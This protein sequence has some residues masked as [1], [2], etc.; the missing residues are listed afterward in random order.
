MAESTPTTR[1]ADPEQ[2]AGPQ[3]QPELRE[4][5]QSDPTPTTL[6]RRDYGA[7]LVRGVREA[8][9]DHVT[10]LQ[11]RSPTTGSSRCR[12]RCSSASAS[13]A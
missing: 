12:R 10:N 9:A 2:A 1:D 5:R 6:S 8:L 7:I 13:S 4:P 11:R 3:P